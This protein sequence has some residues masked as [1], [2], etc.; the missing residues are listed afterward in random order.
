MVRVLVWG[1]RGPRFES[2]LPDLIFKDFPKLAGPCGRYDANFDAN[3]LRSCRARRVSRRRGMGEGSVGR[4]AAGRWVARLQ[5]DGRRR[6][7]YGQTRA[8]AARKL[9][10]AIGQVQ[11]RTAIP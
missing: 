4:H 7:F 9:D 6:W 5:I 3:L 8:E 10:D 11:I 1:T 2:A